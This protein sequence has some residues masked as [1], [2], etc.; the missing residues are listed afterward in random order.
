M[1]YQALARRWRPQTFADVVGQDHVVSALTNALSSGRIHHAFLFSG[2]RGVGKTTLARIFA[3]ALNC[4]TGITAVPCGQCSA[5]VGISEGNYADLLEVDAASR[6]KVEDTREMLE[7]VQYAPSLGRS[8]VYLID[9]VHMLSMHSFN[10][11]LK[12]LEEPPDHVKFLLATTDPQK[13]PATVLSRCIQFNLKAMDIQQL[14]DHMEHILKTEQIAF[15]PDG[16]R[17]IARSAEG[18]VRD[19]LS[20]LDQAIAHGQGEVRSE[21]VRSMLGMIEIHF[22]RELLDA[23]ANQDGSAVLATVA[24]MAQRAVDF[25]EALDDILTALHNVALYQV[26]PD[27]LESKGMDMEEL[28]Q[29]AS[30]V[31]SELL[32]LFYQTALLGKRDFALATDPRSGFEMTLLRM[33]VFQ[34]TH[35]TATASGQTAPSPGRHG[36]SGPRHDGHASRPTNPVKVPAETTGDRTAA[37]PSDPSPKWP[38]AEPGEF[39]LDSAE[40]WSTFATSDRLTGILR[41]LAMHMMPVRMEEGVLTLCLAKGSEVLLKDHRISRIQQLYCEHFGTDLQLRV[42]VQDRDQLTDESPAMRRDRENQQRQA[43]AEKTFQEDPHVQQMIT[44]FHAEIVPG[45]IRPPME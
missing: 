40:G 37:V 5:C 24:E 16:L 2:T 8:R 11:L 45:S 26:N 33:A 15:D 14:Q 21:R 31:D 27:I 36:A 44:R 41:E 20:L 43:Q 35:P 30:R 13:L 39:G 17:V 12:T 1:S 42:T 28:A 7:N 29:M 4:E 34:P 38:D 3:K 19:A 10:A 18:S 22:T 9:E 6:T 32:Q 25:R 23:V